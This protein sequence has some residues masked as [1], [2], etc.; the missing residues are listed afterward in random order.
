ML[1][2]TLAIVTKMA[3]NNLLTKLLNVVFMFPL[4]LFMLKSSILLKI[5]L[6]K[7]IKQCTSR[8]EKILLQ[9][10]VEIEVV[11]S[12]KPYIFITKRNIQ[13]IIV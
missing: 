13:K 12:V 8:E 3:L 1:P 4:F 2:S 6:T 7:L 9:Y 5:I 10:I 11:D